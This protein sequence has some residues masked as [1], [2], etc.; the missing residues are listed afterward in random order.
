MN[1]LDKG[2]I[3][4]RPFTGQRQNRQICAMAQDTSA[5][6]NPQHVVGLP[7][8]CRVR[9]QLRSCS[10]PGRSKAD[11]I[12]EP[13]PQAMGKV[14]ALQHLRHMHQ[15][16]GVTTLTAESQMG[17]DSRGQKCLHAAVGQTAPPRTPPREGSTQSPDLPRTHRSLRPGVFAHQSK[18]SPLHKVA[19]HHADHPAFRAQAAA[20]LLHQMHMAAVEG[21]VFCYDTCNLHRIHPPSNDKKVTFR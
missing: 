12:G 9:C 11:A 14:P 5:V 21:I 19:A 4:G 15:R 8:Q 13:G 7:Q 2:P 6:F 20:N 3:M 16:P 10:L 18:I 17:Y 1:P